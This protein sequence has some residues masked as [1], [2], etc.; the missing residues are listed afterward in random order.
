LPDAY[1]SYICLFTGHPVVDISMILDHLPAMAFVK[2]FAYL[3]AHEISLFL[4]DF[5]AAA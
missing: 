5:E 2:L 4:C 3:C 1:V